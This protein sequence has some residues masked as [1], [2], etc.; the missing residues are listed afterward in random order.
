M[1]SQT[2][3]SFAA[4]PVELNNYYPFGMPEAGRS[5]SYQGVIF[6]YQSKY[7]DY[8]Y[9]FNGMQ[10]DNSKGLGSGYT[11][12]FREYDPEIARWKSLDPKLKDFP[13]ESPFSAMGNNP[14]MNTDV[15]GDS[16]FVYGDNR[17]KVV[18]EMNAWQ[19]LPGR[20]GALNFVLT[21]VT[22]GAGTDG[23]YRLTSNR[24]S[25]KTLDALDL[26]FEG[27]MNDP[28]VNVNLLTFS[29]AKTFTNSEGSSL[30]IDV[31]AYMGNYPS[32]ND[33]N[34]KEAIAAI[35]YGH[36][37]SVISQG[38]LRAGDVTP[39][40]IYESYYSAKFSVGMV[41]AHNA[42]ISVLPLFSAGDIIPKDP[43][44]NVVSWQ[45]ASTLTAGINT[46]QYWKLSH[47]NTKINCF[48]IEWDVNI[49]S[50]GYNNINSI[51]NLFKKR[52]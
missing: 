9:G 34:K 4:I 41:A 36:I 45:T 2:K 40:E 48:D 11:T 50:D 26:A 14:I 52:K 7:Q 12:L 30:N 3:P 1:N 29:S 39:H 6:E 42:T 24:V 17:Q 19:Q 35:H 25:G 46:Y 13:S 5:W 8:T 31:G 27:I 10:R 32:L 37:A 21:P 44:G 22:E 16:V 38:M 28:D 47:P 51:R 33:N 15:L 49:N 23:A 18:D 20:N 43:Q